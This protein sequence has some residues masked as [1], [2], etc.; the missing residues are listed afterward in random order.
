[1][2]KTGKQARHI[3]APVLNFSR[4]NKASVDRPPDVAPRSHM[5]KT[6][7]ISQTSTPTFPRHNSLFLKPTKKV[8]SPVPPSPIKNHQLSSVSPPR[9]DQ[10]LI[11]KS[12]SKLHRVSSSFTKAKLPPRKDIRLSLSDLSLPPS[13]SPGTP[14]SSSASDIVEPTTETTTDV[15]MKSP[16]P[17]DQIGKTRVEPIKTFL[18]IKPDPVSSSNPGYLEI[19]SDTQ[20]RMSPPEELKSRKPV[21][22]KFTKLFGPEAAQR[23][24]FE[25]SCLPML[26]P[27]FLQDNS[28]GLIFAYGA[29]NSGKSHT[30]HGS[31]D[32]SQAGI[33]SRSLAVIFSSIDQFVQ[34]SGEASQY[35]PI[36]YQDVE[37]VDPAGLEDRNGVSRDREQKKQLKRIKTL[38]NKLRHMAERLKLQPGLATPPIISRE[39][40][41]ADTTNVIK[42]PEGMD[43]TV[44]LSCFE[45]YA[46]KIY[47][48]LTEP[49]QETTE[50]GRPIGEPKRTALH[51]KKDIST[52]HKYVHGLKEIK[53]KTLEEALL[54]V[55][56]GLKQ[57]QVFSTLLNKTSSRS[58]C[59]F[60]IKILKTPQFG[61]CASETAAVG[62]TSLSRLSF[63]DLAGSERIRNTHS[64]GQRLREA[65]DINKSLMVLGHCMEVLQTNQNQRP[66][67]PMPVPYRHAKLTQLF[68][69]NFEDRSRNSQVAV[70][71]NVDPSGSDYDETQQSLRFASTASDVATIYEET[72]VRCSQDNDGRIL[73]TPSISTSS[74]ESSQPPADSF[75]KVSFATLLQERDQRLKVLEELREAE[76]EGEILREKTKDLDMLRSRVEE[77]Q[78]LQEQVKG[79]D[80]NSLRTR[81][82]EVR[83]L[84]EQ[85]K[86]VDLDC[87]R[88]RAEEVRTLQEQLKDNDLDTL[89]AKVEEVR[90]R[91][92]EVRTLQEQL[93]DNDVDMLRARAEE[94]RTLQEHLKDNDLDILRARAE[95]VRTLQEHAKGI[96]M[97]QITRILQGGANVLTTM[98]EQEEKIKLLQ[99][100]VNVLMPSQDRLKVSQM[101]KEMVEMLPP[102]EQYK[103]VEALRKEVKELEALRKE[104][105][106]LRLQL[107]SLRNRLQFQQELFSVLKSNG[108]NDSTHCAILA[109][110]QE[111][112]QQLEKRNRECE[113]ALST[114]GGWLASAPMFPNTVGLQ[115]CGCQGLVNQVGEAI[116]GMKGN[117]EDDEGP[118]TDDN[119]SS[120]LSVSQVLKRLG[121]SGRFIVSHDIT[122]TSQA[123]QQTTD[124]ALR[125]T[126]EHDEDAATGAFTEHRATRTNMRKAK[127]VQRST[128]ESDQEG[129]MVLEHRRVSVDSTGAQESADDSAVPTSGESNV[130]Q[131]TGTHIVHRRT[132]TS[133]DAIG[134]SKSN[135]S[136]AIS[137]SSK[138]FSARPTKRKRTSVTLDTAVYSSVGSADD[139]A[140]VMSKEDAPTSTGMA[141]I[142]EKRSLSPVSQYPT[143]EDCMPSRSPSPSPESIQVSASR[144]LSLDHDAR[145]MNDVI[146]IHSETSLSPSTPCFPNF[147]PL[148]QEKVFHQE[149]GPCSMNDEV[150]TSVGAS[151]SPSIPHYPVLEPFSPKKDPNQD[152]VFLPDYQDSEAFFD[153]IEMSSEYGMDSGS[154][155]RQWTPPPRKDTPETTL[156]NLS[157]MH[158]EAGAVNSELVVTG[159][160]EALAEAREQESMEPESEGPEKVGPKTVEPVRVE[161]ETVELETVEVPQKP[162]RRRLRAAKVIMAEEI[163]EQVDMEPPSPQNRRNKRGTR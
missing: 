121:L 107:L 78:A 140:N 112:I 154:E 63:V 17:A 113:S 52:G 104:V 16:P 133:L 3:R 116:R 111:Y 7:R 153:A 156:D 74:F 30:V 94:V 126:I 148:S 76:R 143:L 85:V 114:W 66:K 27:L 45:I 150:P 62:K 48:L 56:A 84:Q 141:L 146:S 1:M 18:R 96:D 81:A 34:D 47:D 90:T 147:G 117:F 86:G 89:R 151:L 10:K 75:D 58:H 102:W 70:I 99:E 92:E 118:P 39:A 83:G 49:R 97:H 5:D 24:V 93:K 101:L 124:T 22:F 61:N 57:R 64:S 158:Y 71:V 46:E 38:D 8:K 37:K 36:G 103:E 135:S 134:S 100:E 110:K 21:F 77:V 14:T 67:N 137:V 136:D 132:S 98:K 29:S 108:Q 159:L 152:D 15:E 55:R 2:A 73:D 11:S 123:Q 119:G 109:S 51:L 91:I 65:G 115:S 43:Y 80:L 155:T 12:P 129:P 87:L 128:A 88:T 79:V 68:Q 162:K 106:E 60:T 28:N 138:D 149:D 19:I 35:R 160:E 139:N 157:T 41:S 50:S 44:W 20:V 125:S 127:N 23:H 4:P 95:E 69:N 142:R 42:L 105:R 40:L 54:V 32:G 33:I 145:S 59:V 122:V 161:L 25:E 53:V 144:S 31:G 6:A 9:K 72:P 131:V 120:K 130:E 13:P 82:E 26:E 163:E